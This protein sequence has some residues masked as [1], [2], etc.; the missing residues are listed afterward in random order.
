MPA[1]AASI[2]GRDTYGTCTYGVC[3]NHTV[4]QTPTGLKVA[5]NLTNGQVIP[6]GGYTITVTP[7]NG[8]GSSFKQVEIY[9]DGVKIA[10]ITPG[11]DGTAYWRWD[12]QAHPGTHI[13]IKVLDS[14]GN[15][16]TFTFDVTIGL[17]TQATGTSNGGRHAAGGQQF[18]VTQF[19]ASVTEKAKQAIKKLPAPLVYVFPY[20]LFV[21][22]LIEIIILLLQTKREL[23]EL[24]T[25]KKLTAEEHEIAAMKQTL[26]EL[27][28]HYLRTPL[29]ILQGG[30]EGLARDGVPPATVASLQGVLAQ[31]HEIIES[32]IATTSP[33]DHVVSSNATNKRRS[34]V[35]AASVAVW[36]PVVLVG[37]VTFGFVYLA[38]EVSQFTT[39][40]LGILTQIVVYSILI[41]VLYQV[42]RRWHLHRRDTH[43]AQ[44][45]LSDEQNIQ[46]IRD[47]VITQTATR[48][49]SQVVAL[50]ALSKSLPPDAPNTKFISR[51]FTQLNTTTSKFV[52][53][54][55]LR[56]A[57]SQESYQTTSLQALYDSVA[58]AVALAATNKQVTIHLASDA[59]FTTQN[60]GLLSLVLQT[61]L[62]NAVGFSKQNSSIELSATTTAEQT[63]I[64]V[65]D[66]GSGVAPDKQAA[67]FRPFFK[68]EGAEEFNREGM[69]FSLY[70]DKLIMGYLGGNI[71]LASE[72]GNF[73]RV[74][75]RLP[76]SKS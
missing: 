34:A 62:D 55:H 75:L 44:K 6:A 2:Y 19:L 14:A 5:V 57:R 54:S 4:V 59:Q 12:P 60:T 20:L 16:T 47:N 7:L 11:E 53:A 23:R 27:V 41:L 40:M 9:I 76:A 28:S 51:G 22:L 38:N 1:F 24:E 13:E 35:L 58:A 73:T 26:I 64:Q 52:I 67:L 56:G 72:P 21:L 42:V 30:A 68:A 29:T 39:N 50:G 17:A 65:T 48:L 71:G 61:V 8:A 46:L 33:S 32:L 45:I 25:T 31:V 66:H 69:G 74:T 37:A 18:F 15:V 43:G 36:L 49:Q 70:L 63:S 3:N 10:T